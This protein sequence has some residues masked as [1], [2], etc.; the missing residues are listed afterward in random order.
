MKILLLNG[1]NLNLLGSR[2]TAVY[3]ERSLND[4][5]VLLSEKFPDHEID[6]FQSNVEGE[7]INKIQESMLHST[8][9]TEAIVANF[10]AYSHT[11]IAIRDALEAI[12]VPKVEVHISNIHAREE[13]RETSITGSVMDGIITGFG[14]NSYVLGILAAEQL[15]RK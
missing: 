15:S 14:F 4:L 8:H 12:S 11:S 1:P 3:G 13:F 9:K 10:G 2:N 6:F 5:E 7:L